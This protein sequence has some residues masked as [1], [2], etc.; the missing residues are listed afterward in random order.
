M[1]ILF[2]QNKWTK[3][4]DIRNHLLSEDFSLSKVNL[5]HK[6]STDMEIGKQVLAIIPPEHKLIG[7]GFIRK[8]SI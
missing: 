1:K 2:R 8:L 3:L 5:V 6:R 4:P 7:N